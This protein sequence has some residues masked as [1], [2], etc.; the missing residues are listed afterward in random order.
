VILTVVL[1]KVEFCYDDASGE[2]YQ[3]MGLIRQ[4][5]LRVSPFVDSCNYV[6]LPKL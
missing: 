6:F 5:T 2:G 4:K 1:I 3:A